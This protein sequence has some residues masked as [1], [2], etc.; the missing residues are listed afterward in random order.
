VLADVLADLSYLDTDPSATEQHQHQQQQQQQQ[1]HLQAWPSTMSRNQHQVPAAG[2]VSRS[3]PNMGQNMHWAPMNGVHGSHS[4]PHSHSEH[5]QP[6]TWM[7]HH[8]NS[9][10]LSPGFPITSVPMPMPHQP[11]METQVGQQTP[12]PPKMSRGMSGLPKRVSSEPNFMARMASRSVVDVSELSP[13]RPIPGCSKAQDG[14]EC[15]EAAG[16]THVH[17]T[18]VENGQTVM[19]CTHHHRTSDREQNRQAVQRY[20]KKKKSELQDLRTQN[21]AQKL[22]LQSLRA[23]INSLEKELA[24]AR[25]DLSQPGLELSR[26]RGLIGSIQHLVNTPGMRGEMGDA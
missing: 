13:D 23:T 6:Q 8:V 4:A 1:Q 21:E 5:G 18:F 22:E 7:G 26:M 24:Q 3:M 10:G 16:C 2:G 19:H 14:R 11:S 12:D 20:R 9:Q 17:E 15:S 25:T